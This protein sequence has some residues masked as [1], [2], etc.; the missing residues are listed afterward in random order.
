MITI[1]IDHALTNLEA[2]EIPIKKKPNSTTYMRRP[3]IEKFDLSS[4]NPHHN[5]KTNNMEYISYDPH[6]T[7]LLSDS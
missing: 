1:T 3:Q 5:Y 4:Q 6:R 2:P 7:K